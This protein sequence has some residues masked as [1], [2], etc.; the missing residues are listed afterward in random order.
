MYSHN[1]Y[2][3]QHIFSNT[4]YSFKM[5]LINTLQYKK[6]QLFCTIK[7]FEFNKIRGNELNLSI[8]ILHNTYYN[9]V[10]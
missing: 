10:A 7:L 4:V 5:T 6:T 3:N 9:P 2:T 8:V 1:S